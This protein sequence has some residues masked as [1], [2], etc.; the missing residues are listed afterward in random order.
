[1]QWHPETLLHP[2]SCLLF[3]EFVHAASKFC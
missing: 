2:A 3:Q 1:V